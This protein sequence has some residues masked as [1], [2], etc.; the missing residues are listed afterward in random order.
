MQAMK[1]WAK[2]R[3]QD[4]HNAVDNGLRHT[5][6]NPVN[7]AWRILQTSASP[8]RPPP[9]PPSP[10]SLSSQPPP[11]TPLPGRQESDNDLP[12]LPSNDH[13]K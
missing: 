2:N 3:G 10:P 8:V 6:T 7:L 9:P 4:L 13:S 12:G 1:S 11:R 5:Y